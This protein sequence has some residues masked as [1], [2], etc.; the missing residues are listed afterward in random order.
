MKKFIMVIGAVAVGL[1]AAGAVAAQPRDAVTN[2]ALETI[3][4]GSSFVD[5]LLKNDRPMSRQEAEAFVRSFQKS[6]GSGVK[7]PSAPEP[8]SEKPSDGGTMD[9]SEFL[10]ICQRVMQEIIKVD[11]GLL[12]FAEKGGQSPLRDNGRRQEV[13]AQFLAACRSGQKSFQFKSIGKN[14]IECAELTGGRRFGASSRVKP[15]DPDCKDTPHSFPES[16]GC[17]CEDGYVPSKAQQACIPA[18]ES[19]CEGITKHAIVDERTG[20]CYCKSPYVLSRDGRECIAPEAREADGLIAAAAEQIAYFKKNLN[21]TWRSDDFP[22]LSYKPTRGG[23]EKFFNRE[24]SLLPDGARE[25]L[26]NRFNVALSVSRAKIEEAEVKLAAAQVD[27]V[28]GQY[29]SAVI[30]AREVKA[31]LE[32]HYDSLVVAECALRAKPTVTKQGPYT[33]T[34]G[35]TLPAGCD[36]KNLDFTIMKRTLR[37][38]GPIPRQSYTT[39]RT[40]PAC[41]AMAGEEVNVSEPLADIVVNDHYGKRGLFLLYWSSD[42]LYADVTV[43]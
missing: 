26:A 40:I 31:L 9:E 18:N 2:R 42:W 29:G 12:Q 39:L 22:W 1:A 30:G 5:E 35:L 25:K 10:T 19:Q 38:I 21:R 32:G 33:V 23:T 24:V 15:G 28:V 34:P 11:E 16:G 6:G 14:D 27:F 13:C 41:A 37:L 4:K 7:P 20:K 36:C 43:K 8:Q 3:K 17:K